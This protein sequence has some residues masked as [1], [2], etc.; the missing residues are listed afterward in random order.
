MRLKLTVNGTPVDRTIEDGT[1]LLELLR[2]ELRLTGSKEGCGKGE[3]GACTVIVDGLTY[4]ACLVLAGQCE[5]A[6]VTTIEGLSAGGRL[7]PV[8]QA[9]LE[10][11]A[12]QCG[13]CTPGLVVSAAQLLSAH[14]QPTRAQIHEGLEGNL[15]RC[16]GY[17]KVLRAVE[18]A[19]ARS[20]T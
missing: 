14:S 1:T 19:S 7:H 9:F 5:G 2:E 15:C 13:F 17:T 3:C 10:E 20:S 18:R 4:D 8:Q 12:V 6:A 11:G 16:T